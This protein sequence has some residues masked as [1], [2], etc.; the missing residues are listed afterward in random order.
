MSHRIRH[1]SC[2][3]CRRKKVKCN[4]QYP[5]TR[6]LKYGEAC[7]YDERD[8]RKKRHSLSYLHSL[9]S[10]LARLESF[11]MTLKNSDPEGRDEMLKSVV[12]SDH[13]TEPND[14]EVKSEGPIE[15]PVFLNVQDS[16]TVSFYGPTSAYDLSLPDITKDNKTTW[17]FQ[18]SYSPMVS[19]CLKLFFRYQYSQF[20]FVY[21]ESFLSDYYYNFHD[22]FYCTEHLIYA[23]CAIGAS[24]SDDENISRH[25]K[26]Y[27]DASWQK[28][29]EFGLDRSHLTSVQCLLCLGY[30]DIGMGNTSLGWLLSGLAFRMG[31]DLGFQL[32]PEN[33]YIDN[34]PAISS[35]DSDI[36]RRVFW[37][38]YVADKFIGF[39]M[40]RPTM[41]KRSDASIP[42]SNQLPEFAGLE[43]FK[44]NV[45]DYMSLTDFSVCD[46]VALF[47]DLSDIADSILLNMFSPTSKNRATNIN[48]VLSNLGKYNLELMNWHYK[49]PDTIS[50]RTIDLKKDRIPNLCAVSLYYHLIRICLN[51]PFLSRKE[52]TAN[53]LTP[54]T[55]C[56]DSINEIVTV[57]RAH[58]TANGLRYSTLYI[59]YA[60][61]VSC[62]VIL[63]LRDMCTDSELLTLNNDMMFF[64]E[65]LKECSQ[66]WKLAQRS[67]V[68]IENTLK[69]KTNSQSTSEFVSPISDTENGS[70]SQQVSEAKDIVEPSDVLDELQ[71]FDL[72]PE[73]DD[74]FQ[75]FQAFYGG[76]PIIL[77]PNLYEKKLNEK[78]L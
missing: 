66:T 73:N 4:R 1:L 49:L 18:A 7:T 35:A 64:I 53:D 63:L 13:L 28:L 61:I 50:W 25:S 10:Q 56:T 21:R 29:L 48:C 33:W 9:E 44:L 57:I 5:C 43:E 39:I 41:L 15:Y 62:S 6:C 65:V 23:I 70:S 69:G 58:R 36:R 3:A 32:N 76:P 14:Q 26:S 77:S 16:K 47:V 74:N 34:S 17:N 12:F 68:L 31:Q 11:I 67:I 72:L 52:V 22:G 46:A 38:S 8:N 60:A 27:Y 71:K 59:V 30:Y 19:E 75:T 42:G 24:M 55:I 2:L 51:R 54:K 20:L 40:G 45:T 78:T 37:G